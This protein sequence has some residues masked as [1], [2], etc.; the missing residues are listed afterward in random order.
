MIDDQRILRAEQGPGD[1]Q[2]GKCRQQT[3]LQVRITLRIPFR[4]DE[5]N[6]MEPWSGT[7]FAFALHVVAAV[8]QYI[9]N[10]GKKI[11]NVLRDDPLCRYLGVVIV[12]VS[13][14]YI[15]NLK[16]RGA[17]VVVFVPGAD[18]IRGKNLL[19]RDFVCDFDFV[20]IQ[21]VGC[22]TNVFCRV[23]D[24]WCIFGHGDHSFL[25]FSCSANHPAQIVQ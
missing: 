6:D 23:Y 1:I 22:V 15:G 25:S 2:K 18:H 19:C 9:G 17:T 11:R 12:T 3:L 10:I 16:I 5:K 14:Q 24:D 20:G 7:F 8:V 13:W 21:A 4:A